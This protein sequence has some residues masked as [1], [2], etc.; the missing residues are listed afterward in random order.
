MS[1]RP[2]LL[3]LAQ[4]A[5]DDLTPDEARALEAQ[6]EQSE[7]GRRQLAELRQN[8]AQYE[9]DAGRQWALLRA[10]L[11]TE[12]ATAAAPPWWRRLRYTLPP[13]AAAAAAAIVLL[14]IHTREP[15]QP[16]AP[17]VAFK[18]VLAVKVVAK[19]GARQ[20]VVRS[21]ARMEAGDALRFIVTTDGPGYVSVF[22]VDGKGKVSPF[23]PGTDPRNSP[24]PLRI[25]QAGR[26][27][28]EGSVV[29]DDA[30]GPEHLVVVYSPHAFQ[31]PS[32]HLRIRKQLRSG[33]RA[34]PQVS[35]RA[36]GVKGAVEVITVE[37]AA[38]GP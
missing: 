4:L 16:P 29:L 8:V 24:A 1:D 35:A 19:R 32:A 13:V 18:G 22:S 37:K 38:E 10:R 3:K 36:V 25:R 14:L 33:A 6:L 23:Y 30:P 2:S 28:L 12:A 27:V 31:R 20:F 26:R 21:G 34:A 11:T 9:A 7:E 17:D 15:V 5:S